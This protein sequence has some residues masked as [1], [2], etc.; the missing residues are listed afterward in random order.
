LK[1][2]IHQSNVKSIKF[3]KQNI[4]EIWDTM[5]RSSLRILVIKGKDFSA[6]KSRKYFQ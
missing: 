4:Q 1:K 2:S 6:Q 3:L 5:K